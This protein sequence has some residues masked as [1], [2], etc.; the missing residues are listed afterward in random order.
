MQYACNE[1][2]LIFNFHAGQPGISEDAQQQAAVALFEALKH[3]QHALAATAAAALGHAGLRGSLPL[4]Q[5]LLTPSHLA[6]PRKT[7]DASPSDAKRPKSPVGETA[8][9]AAATLGSSAGK[10]IRNDS[11]KAAAA[12]DSSPPAE[13]AADQSMMQKVMVLTKDK[14]VKVVQKAA[15]AAGHICAGHAVKGNLDP[16][17]E[18]L[19][20][21][22]FNKNEDVLF[23][24]GEA[25][26]FAFGG[27]LSLAAAAHVWL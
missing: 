23:T 1:V 17:L 19:F 16:A 26:C 22:G 4:P 15:T 8:A 12:A 27:D 10:D 24:V 7:S 3:S 25:L 11:A 9:A 13:A 6:D 18:G 14:D 20:A 5:A 2:H 21:L